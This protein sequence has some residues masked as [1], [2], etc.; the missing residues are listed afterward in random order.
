LLFSTD[1]LAFLTSFLTG[2]AEALRDLLFDESLVLAVADL[3]LSFSLDFLEARLFFVAA[4][5]SRFR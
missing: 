3:M 4:L 1:L 5:V 2:L